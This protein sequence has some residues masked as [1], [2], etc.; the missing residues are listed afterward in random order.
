MDWLTL[1]MGLLQGGVN[2]SQQKTTA[3]A[4]A[5]YQAYQNEMTQLSNGVAQNGITDNEI[6]SNRAFA[7]EGLQIQKQDLVSLAQAK[8]QAA[9]SGVSGGSVNDTL[10]NI[11]RQAADANSQRQEQE[12][13][14]WVGYDDQ[15]QNTAMAAATHMNYSPIQQPSLATNL[16]S[17]GLSGLSNASRNFPGGMGAMLQSMGKQVQSFLPSMSSITS[18]LGL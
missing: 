14:S 7:Q 8:V 11:N 15:R 17:G 18:F 4:Q 1:G 9:A 2:Y 5:A 10:M 13:E 6:F 3:K 16:L 12:E